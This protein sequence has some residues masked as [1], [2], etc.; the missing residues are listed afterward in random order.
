M[1]VINHNHKDEDDNNNID[2]QSSNKNINELIEKQ[3]QL[4][5]LREDLNETNGKFKKKRFNIYAFD[6]RTSSFY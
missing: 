5:L 3:N 6:F 2:E 4:G 1:I